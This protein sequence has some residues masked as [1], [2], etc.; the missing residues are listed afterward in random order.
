MTRQIYWILKASINEGKSDQLQALA[1]QFRE[2]TEAE[3]RAIGYEW[4]T[5]GNMLHIYERY[6]DSDA[7]LEHTAN[8]G[9]LLPELVE[10]VTP[11]EIECYGPTTEGFREA[12]KDV[13]MV[14]FDTFEGF[15]R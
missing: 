4:S 2:L 8:I 3:S 14:Y 13:P 10:L 7:A 12:F 5:N 6:V 9:S 1:K 11:V 15:H